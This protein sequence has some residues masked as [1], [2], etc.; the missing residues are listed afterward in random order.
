MGRP[1]LARI[2]LVTGTV[3]CLVLLSALPAEARTAVRDRMHQRALV[4]RRLERLRDHARGHIRR[5]R[6]ETGRVPGIRH[7]IAD[8][9]QVFR[10]RLDRR[11]V[12]WARLHHLASRQQRHAF[13][14]LDRWERRTASRLRTLLQRRQELSSWLSRY[15]IFEVCPVPGYTTI[16]D[17]FGVIVDL[18]HVPRH[19]HM[20]NDVTAPYGAT[21]RAPFDGVASASGSPLGG[22]QV[23]VRGPRGEAFN[24]HLSA[25][26]RLGTVHAGDVIG[27]V[28]STG[29]S[30][31]P[32]DH[33]EWH[34][35][36][37]SAVDPHALLVAACVELPGRR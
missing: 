34:P 15:G 22:Y 2:H 35:G 32:H 19:V 26:G 23:T 18:P 28:G 29:D 17:N 16:N 8:P 36:G 24:A 9:R 33:F 7:E 13:R 6:A 37:G 5:V 30:T 25:Y 21:I 3:V 11:P 12:T 20:G 4:E 31:A 1:R 14:K 10:S 27:Y